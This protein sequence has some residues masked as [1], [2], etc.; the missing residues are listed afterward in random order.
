[1]YY[2]GLR[3]RQE[4]EK[5]E[6]LFKEIITDNFPYLGRDLN[7]LLMKL[8]SHPEIANQNDLLQDIL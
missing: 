7:I 3:R 5:I 1:M 6:S 4:G 8:I 2:Q